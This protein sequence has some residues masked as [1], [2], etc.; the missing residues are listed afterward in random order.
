MAAAWV[1][2]ALL[3]PLACDSVTDMDAAEPCRQAGFSI[4]ARTEACT[5]DASLANRRY[6]ALRDRYRCAI[7]TPTEAD[8]LCSRALLE[9]SC[10]KVLA[11]GDD[12]AAWLGQSLRCL[13]ILVPV[14]GGAAGGAGS[15]GSGAGGDAGQGGAGG[16]VDAARVPSKNDVCHGI[17]AAFNAWRIRCGFGDDPDYGSVDERYTCNAAWSP[18]DGPPPAELLVCRD[19]LLVAPCPGEPIDFAMWLA[20]NPDC[21]VHFPQR[22]K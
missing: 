12:H 5:K 1:S 6:E 4:A 7:Q 3:A 13:Q 15:G 11:Y 17:H 14:V 9:T 22:S 16:A 19:R 10:E 21:Q 2:A 20:Q 18:M 8:F